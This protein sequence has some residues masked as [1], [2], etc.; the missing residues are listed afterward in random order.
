MDMLDSAS[1][2]SAVLDGVWCVLLV[3][4]GA[5]VFRWVVRL[6]RSLLEQG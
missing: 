2:V 3:A 5:W 1:V 6:L 4:A